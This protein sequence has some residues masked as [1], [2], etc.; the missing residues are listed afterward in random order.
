MKKQEKRNSMG[1][2]GPYVYRTKTGEQFWLH[3]KE[4]G[5]T[6]LYYFSKDP[7]GALSSIPKEYEIV[8]NEKTPLPFLKKK[9]AKKKEEK[10]T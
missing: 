10:K 7:A 2:F 9:E 5:K 8:K 6:K 3:V 1:L 4:K